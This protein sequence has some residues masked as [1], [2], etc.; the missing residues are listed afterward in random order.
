MKCDACIYNYIIKI[1]CFKLCHEFDANGHVLKSTMFGCKW[2]YD[3]YCKYDYESSFK[4][5]WCRFLEQ[6][7]NVEFN[8]ENDYMKNCYFNSR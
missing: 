5:H 8:L 2:T 6:Y 4:I 1:Q 3:Q 7:L